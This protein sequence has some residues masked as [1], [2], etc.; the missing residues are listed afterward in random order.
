MA[1]IADMFI[2]DTDGQGSGG[3]DEVR[4][5][6]PVKPGDRLTLER[7]V[8]GKRVSRSR[9]DRGIVDF[10]FRLLDAEGRPVMTQTNTIMI[11]LRHG[12]PA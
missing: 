3:V 6:R 4:W 1:M 8:T 2:L 5:L 12:E 9:P 7:T 11:G 10:A